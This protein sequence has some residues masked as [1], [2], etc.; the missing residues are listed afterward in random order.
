MI[1]SLAIS[2]S[3]FVLNLPTPILIDVLL[4][5][6]LIPSSFKTY[7]GDGLEDVQADPLEIAIWGIELIIDMPLKNGNERLIFPGI[8][9]LFEPFNFV[10]GYSD[11]TV[12]ISLSHSC[13]IL[14]LSESILFNAISHA[15]PNPT[16]NGA[17]NVP[18]LKLFSCSPPTIMGFNLIFDYLFLIYYAPTPFGP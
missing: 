16:I 13:L 4:S 10:S 14:L 1:A 18:D 2:I 7:E 17:G 9:F 8:L 15:L 3:L 12:L 5:N 6:L 11:K